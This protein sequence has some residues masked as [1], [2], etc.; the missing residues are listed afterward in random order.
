MASHKRPGMM[1]L[2]MV[3]LIVGFLIASDQG[4]FELTSRRVPFSRYRDQRDTAF[5]FFSKPLQLFASGLRK[6]VLSRANSIFLTVDLL[7]P[8]LTL[9]LVY[10]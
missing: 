1:N 6:P 10:T 5:E 3:N 2:T 7:I 8:V 9:R 4:G